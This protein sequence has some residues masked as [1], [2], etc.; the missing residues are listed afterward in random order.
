VTDRCDFALRVLAWRRE[1]DLPARAQVLSLEESNA[2]LAFS[3]QQGCQQDRLTGG[4][5]L[6]SGAALVGSVQPHQR[7]AG[8]CVSWF[9]TTNGS[10]VEQTGQPLADAGVQRLNISLDSLDPRNS[11]PL[12]V[13]GDRANSVLDWD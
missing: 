6:G 8:P 9:M 4:E 5:P 2:W 11:K 13:T 10:A 1:I 12:P 7:T 3:F